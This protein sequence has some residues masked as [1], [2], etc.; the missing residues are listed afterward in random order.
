MATE[1]GNIGQDFRFAPENGAFYPERAAASGFFVRDKAKI[2]TLRA[3]LMK[4]SFSL[5][6]QNS[7]FDGLVVVPLTKEEADRLNSF[8]ENDGRPKAEIVRQAIEEMIERESASK[9]PG[10]FQ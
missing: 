10:C 8:A 2:Y 5:K 9:G 6:D 4:A 3:G 1:N 7:Q